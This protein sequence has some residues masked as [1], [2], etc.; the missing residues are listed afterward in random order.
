[1][2]PFSFVLPKVDK[3]DQG[4][5]KIIVTY[6][7]K[8]REL[9]THDYPEI[10]KIPGLYENLFYDTLDCQS[11]KVV[12]GLLGDALSQTDDAPDKLVALDVGAGN[13][14]VGE[15]LLEIGAQKV[16]GVDIIPE[17]AEAAERDRPGVY[18][19][20]YVE[21]LTELPEKVEDEITCEGP[22]CLSIVAA[23]GFDDIPP[24]AFATGY[25]LISDDGWIAFNIKDEFL[26]K[27]HPSGFAS[28][29]DRMV[30]EDIMDIIDKKR[31]QHR[32]CLD[33]TPLN[34]YA[35]VG[36]KQADISD[37]MLREFQ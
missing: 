33:G 21:D 4:K 35:V 20:Y 36:K 14:M 6:K 5:E 1:M 26:Q 25:N 12:C 9:V 32:L 8:T 15:E 34:Y 30:D 11:P 37:R 19:A 22:N 27:N 31:Y 28:L 3:A 2:K 7:G 24:D 18:D 23:L 29:I 16:L 10:Y 13:G 17:A